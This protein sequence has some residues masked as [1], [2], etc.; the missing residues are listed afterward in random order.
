MAQINSSLL[1]SIMNDYKY[2][3]ENHDVEALARIF[4]PD[5]E[6]HEKPNSIFYGL[7]EIKIY[8][9][10]LKVTQRHVAFNIKEIKQSDDMNI[11]IWTA[12]FERSDLNEQWKL[13]GIMLLD[14]KG[15]KITKLKEY[16]FSSNQKIIDSTCTVL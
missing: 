15:G 2:A 14:I 6:Y 12:S 3:W 16:F 7:D 13:D 8:W 9:E 1:Q 5:A 4:S 10:T 11:V